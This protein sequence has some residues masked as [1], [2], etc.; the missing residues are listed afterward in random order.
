MSTWLV[1]APQRAEDEAL[2]RSAWIAEQTMTL[3]PL[4][5][6]T[7]LGGEAT[8]AA[9]GAKVQ[10][11]P[12]LLGVAFFGHGG[13]DRLFDAERAPGALEPALLDTEN[14]GLLAGRWVHA[15]ACWSG[16]T[17]ATRA[18]LQGATI[19]VGYDQPLDAG[20]QCPPPAAAEFAALTSC[21]TLALL[22]GERDPRVLR[23]AASR[24]AD[25]FVEALNAIPDSESIQGWMW[26]HKLAQD[27]VDHLVVVHRGAAM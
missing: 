15:F 10:E 23:G 4:R 22:A 19:Y 1:V 21:V 7:L 2:Q 13:E 14:A 3:A 27:L 11:V 16:K 18:V 6:L 24:A 25:A 17:L 9:F 8:R 26:L 5:P 20:W 12:T